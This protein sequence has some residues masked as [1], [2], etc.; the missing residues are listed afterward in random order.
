MKP[1]VAAAIAFVLS[2]LV[3]VPIL[4]FFVLF[5]VGDGGQVELSSEMRQVVFLASGVVL[6]AVS[7]WFAFL[8]YRR[9]ASVIAGRFV[10]PANQDDVIKFRLFLSAA[11]FGF[12]VLLV[13]LLFLDIPLL[14]RH[15]TT[16]GWITGIGVEPFAHRLGGKHF[17]RTTAYYAYIDRN[18]VHYQ[19]KASQSTFGYERRSDKFTVIYDPDNPA[20]HRV[21]T[22]WGQFG[23]VGLI[24]FGLLVGVGG[25]R[26]CCQVKPRPQRIKSNGLRLH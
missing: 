14:L 26:K 8:V 11:I 17:H 4:A 19:R 2:L 21:L 20:R 5:L 18:G 16:Q 3:L 15:E 13:G 10:I 6:V 9:V 12:A 22:L 7:S 1:Y 23:V 25:Y 24:V